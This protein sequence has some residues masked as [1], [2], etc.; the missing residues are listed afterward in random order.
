MKIISVANLKFKNVY[1]QFMD[2]TAIVTALQAGTL[3]MSAGGGIGL[4]PITD[5]NA[6]RQ[7][8]SLFVEANPG[9][10]GQFMH[11]NN[12]VFTDENFRKALLTAI[13]R[14]RLVT[15]LLMGEGGVIAST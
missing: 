11:I 7:N 1:I 4:I 13:N 8:E 9:T 14:D 2:S 10:N 12:E 6:L 5:I 3:D 15:D